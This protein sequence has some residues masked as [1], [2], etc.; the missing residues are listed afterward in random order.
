MIC[1]RDIIKFL[2]I[3]IHL[4]IFL[5]MIIERYLEVCPCCLTVRP[6]LS[7]NIEVHFSF[8]KFLIEFF[9]RK[10]S[11]FAGKNSYSLES[12][13]LVLVM[14]T[15]Q[16]CHWYNFV[17]SSDCKQCVKVKQGRSFRW[18]SKIPS[19]K[20]IWLDKKEVEHFL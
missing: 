6:D 15:T 20:W 10:K 9:L 7:S 17:I 1:I 16:Q 12:F 5:K 18:V 13:C 8:W 4:I 19:C 2:H 14:H 3:K 11:I